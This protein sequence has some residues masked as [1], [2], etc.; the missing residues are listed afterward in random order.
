MLLRYE[1]M[2][3]AKKSPKD[4]KLDWLTVRVNGA[5]LA[6]WKDHAARAK[7]FEEEPDLDFSAWVRRTLDKAMKTE[8]KK[9]AKKG[10]SR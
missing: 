6:R 3:P 2:A 4:S 1:A 10:G 8:Q 5:K 7:D 9:M